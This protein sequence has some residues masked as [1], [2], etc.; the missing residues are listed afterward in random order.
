MFGKGES[1][2]LSS[3]G[4]EAGANGG[5]EARE[6]DFEG[7]FYEGK[8]HPPRVQESCTVL[9]HRASLCRYR[10][11]WLICVQDGVCS[12]VPPSPFGSKVTF[13]AITST[14]GSVRCGWPREIAGLVCASGARVLLPH[15]PVVPPR[16]SQ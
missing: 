2:L 10:W 12:F 15:L 11:V 13:A 4:A 9:Q 1:G 14:T 6:A 5:A 7:G 16:V 8:K 3:F